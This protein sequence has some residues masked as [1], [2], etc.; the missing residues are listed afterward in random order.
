M[1]EPRTLMT[2]IAFGESPRW[3]DGR[4]WFSDWGAG[5]VIAV[6]TTGRSEVITRI[7]GFP[8]CIDF[9]P[10]GRLLVVSPGERNLLRREA[11]GS[12]VTHVELAHLSELGW[13]D[14]GVDSHGNVFVG[15]VNFAFGRG[16][17]YQPGMV[18]VARPDGSAEQ[19][20]DGLAFPNGIMVSADDST[21]IVAESYGRCLTGF[22]IAADG[23]LSGRR[24]WADL[25]AAAAPDGIC[26]DAE[27]AV[28]YGDVPNRCCVRVAEGGEVLQ[29][30]DL[31]HGCFSCALGGDDGRQLFMVVRSWAGS[32]GMDFS[33]RGGRVLVV[34][35]D[36]PGLDR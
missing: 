8:F 4:L 19:V 23:T 29:R 12:F 7:D 34:D 33:D 27:G 32:A 36:V 30:F 24:V 9:L 2:G 11:D 14:I 16:G 13:N 15:N 31:E 21:L 1:Q 35:V 22:D 25:G 28:W 3:H 26:V 17:E 6:D 18:A 10:D 5:E 20:A